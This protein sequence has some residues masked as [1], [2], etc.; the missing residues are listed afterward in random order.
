MAACLCGRGSLEGV[1]GF[2]GSVESPSSAPHSPIPR[3]SLQHLLVQL[4]FFFF[5]EGGGGRL[6]PLAQIV[7]ADVAMWPVTL[8]TGGAV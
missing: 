7:P 8:H 2:A 3:S 1:W 6:F 4:G 5:G